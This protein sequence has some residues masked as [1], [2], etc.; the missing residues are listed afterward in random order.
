MS[1]KSAQYFLN[2]MLKDDAWEDF[3]ICV[4]CESPYDEWSYYVMDGMCE[5]CT[6]FMYPYKS[7]SSSSKSTTSKTTTKTDNSVV[8][9]KIKVVGGG[10][11]TGYPPRTLTE[12]LLLAEKVQK[13]WEDAG[14]APESDE[15]EGPSWAE[16]AEASNQIDDED[17]FEWMHGWSGTLR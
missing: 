14:I 9:S 7:G 13:S 1:D 12:E 17:D 3:Q 2:E 5:D 16:V 8:T 11:E 15:D 10:T 6:C 4:L